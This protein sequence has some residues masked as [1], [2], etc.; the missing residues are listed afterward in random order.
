MLA[1]HYP[2]AGEAVRALLAERM[3]ELE[4]TP[5]EEKFAADKISAADIFTTQFNNKFD[6]LLYPLRS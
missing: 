3:A 6:V 2:P 1:G 5:N 4:I